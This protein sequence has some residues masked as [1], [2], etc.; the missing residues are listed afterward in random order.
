[1]AGIKYFIYYKLLVHNAGVLG[2][3]G[4]WVLALLIA[5]VR[6]PDFLTP[7]Q[8]IAESL[9][10]FIS[11]NAGDKE[12]DHSPSK[13]PEQH[14]TPQPDAPPAQNSTAVQTEKKEE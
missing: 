11:E 8:T 9:T 7:L 10:T 3:W 14:M 4:F 5:V 6:V 2:F 13:Q 1:M 12:V